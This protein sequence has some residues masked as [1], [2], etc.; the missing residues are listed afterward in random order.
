MHFSFSDD[1]D[2]SLIIKQID[3]FLRR[4]ICGRLLLFA[5]I[6][7]LLVVHHLLLKLL[8]LVDISKTVFTI[9]HVINFRVV[10]SIRRL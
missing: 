4:F 2:I 5:S 10:S 3:I 6:I 9:A 7:S 1:G 8:V